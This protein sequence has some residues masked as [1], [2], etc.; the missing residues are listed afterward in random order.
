MRQFLN[1]FISVS[2]LTLML[3]LLMNL[4]KFPVG[5]KIETIVFFIFTFGIVG[6]LL[7]YKNLKEHIDL[8]RQLI[9]IGFF[10][11][12][13]FYTIFPVFWYIF[14]YFAKL[15]IYSMLKNLL[16]LIFIIF[17]F[18]F[19]ILVPPI[20]TKLLIANKSKL[21]DFIFILL[22]TSSFFLIRLPFFNDSFYLRFHPGKYVS[23]VP[24]AQEMYKA[25]NPFVF[26]NP[27]YTGIF[28]SAFDQAFISFWRMPILEWT[29]APFFAL[30]DLLT[31]EAIVRTY[32]TLVGIFVIINFYFLLKKL[33][34]QSSAMITT[35]LLVLTPLFNLLTWTTTLDLPAIVFL[36]VALNLYLRNHKN[37]SFLVLG[38]AFSIKLSFVIIGLPFFGF[39]ILFSKKERLFSWLKLGFLSFLP[40]ALFKLL[41]QNTPSNP[42]ALGNNIFLVILFFTLLFIIYSQ[43]QQKLS[44]I[45]NNIQENRFWRYFLIPVGIFGVITTGSALLWNSFKSLGTQFLTDAELI[46]NFD[47]YSVLIER[48]RLM[49]ISF[50]DLLFICSIP[51]TLRL[52][53][54]KTFLL[55]SMLFSSLIY[56]VLAS[57]S[58]RFAWYY[59]HFFILTIFTFFASFIYQLE[60]RI[61]FKTYTSPILTV[62][63]ISIVLF[64]FGVKPT[65][66]FETKLNHSQINLLVKTIESKTGFNSKLIYLSSEYKVFY[67]YTKKPFVPISSMTSTADLAK[68]RKEIDNYGFYKA[69]NNHGVSLLI[70]KEQQD[71]FISLTYLFSDEFDKTS[72]ER[73]NLILTKLDEEIEYYD[74]PIREDYQRVM[75]QQYFKQL[76]TVN[77]VAIYEIVPEATVSGALAQ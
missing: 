51:L 66:V 13:I 2:F 56:L 61:L 45:F 18:L 29:L 22:I 46:L 47:F 8:I 39:L 54:K 68:I 5:L 7:S 3:L 52:R 21:L 50:V 34:S 6:F 11:T 71:N 38:F 27:V 14:A 60:N 25:A 24:I 44:L 35:L 31:I 58:I 74:E 72:T 43:T 57:K 41:L 9:L 4:S 73:T 65:S 77:G 17:S 1:K 23:Y 36:L 20:K 67:L 64:Q 53:R 33:F 55:L 30:E 75:P 59:N 48:I 28:G 19:I 70:D 10:S 76:K 16:M 26:K 62:C 32:L 42:M 63:I 15:H 37:L 40:L 49:S 69:M 12:T